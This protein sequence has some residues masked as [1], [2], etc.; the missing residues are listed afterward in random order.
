MNIG[1]I[2]AWV[3]AHWLDTIVPGYLAVVGLA[4]WIVKITPTLKDDSVLLE[5]IKFI[6]KYLAINTNA[7]TSRPS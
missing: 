5:I 2:I 4:S 1:E 3:Q 6:A 7:P